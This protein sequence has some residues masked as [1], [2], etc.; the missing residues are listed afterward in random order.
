MSSMLVMLR[1]RIRI[2]IEVNFTV[3]TVQYNAKIKKSQYNEKNNYIN[4]II[5]LKKIVVQG[6][7]KSTQCYRLQSS[8][9]ENI[10]H[11]II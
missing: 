5:L 10:L 11:S 9:G 1:I 7:L 4:G 6:K 8:F 2:F 3:Q